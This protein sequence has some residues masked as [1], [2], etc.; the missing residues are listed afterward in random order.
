MSALPAK[1]DIVQHG[2]N[3]PFGEN[4]DSC[5]AALLPDYFVIVT[6]KGRQPPVEQ[7]RGC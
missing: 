2:G 1:A 7:W 5:G 4:G 6:C 3:V